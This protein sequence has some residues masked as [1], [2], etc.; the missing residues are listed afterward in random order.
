[1][2]P[3]AIPTGASP[4]LADLTA[5][6][7]TDLFDAGQRAGDQPRWLDSDLT[8]AL[9]RSNDRYSTVAPYLKEVLVP[10]FPSMRIYPTPSD[11]WFIDAAEYPYGQW[12][13]WWQP[14][15]EKVSALVMPPPPGAG[16][17][18]FGAGG[19]LSAGAYSWIVTFLV[20]GGGETTGILLGTGSA[21]INQAATLT[22]PRGPYGVSDR[23]VYRT[24]AGGSIYYLA[25]TA[26]DNVSTSFVDTAADGSI[27]GGRLIPTS[28]TTQGIAQF[29]LQI[30]DAKLPSS[31]N[32]N[33]QDPNYGWIG[34]RYAAKHELDANGTTIPERH[35]DVLCLGAE[36]FAI[37]AYLVPTADNFHYVDGQFRDQVDDTKV[38]TAWLAIGQDLEHRFLNRL[39]EIKQEDNAGVAAIGSRFLLL[40]FWEW[41]FCSFHSPDWW[42]KH[43]EKTRLVTVESAGLVA[44]GWNLWLRWLEVCK[45]Y[46]IRA[47]NGKWSCFERMREPASG[48]RGWW[49]GGAGNRLKVEG[50]GGRLKVEG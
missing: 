7:R 16:S 47:A 49:L 40:A 33:G 12:P 48:S 21:L 26:G 45:Q 5:R 17:V 11:A 8:R 15:V 25:G 18:S 2:S 20:P 31:A 23:N 13:K 37:F 4:S 24:L 44:G 36:F 34:L 35:W 28:N 43:W 42:R 50:E 3:I 6:V 38:P 14:V 1:M 30:S 41:D 9:D 32:A 29:E 10:T 22:I 39:A 46:G 27:T 19:H